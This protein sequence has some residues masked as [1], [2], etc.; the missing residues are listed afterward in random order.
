MG[1]QRVTGEARTFLEDSLTRSPTEGDE[2][3][4]RPIGSR[5]TA[6]MALLFL[7]PW[8]VAKAQQATK[9]WHVGCLHPNPSE[10]GNNPLGVAFEKG[11]AA[12]G[13]VV[14]TTTQIEYLFVRPSADKLRQAAKELS[15]R[16]DVLVVWGTVSAIAAKEAGIETPVVFA[17]VG[18]PVALGLA[19]SLRKPGGNFTGISF[20]AADDTYGK[21]LQMLKEMVPGLRRVA[22]LGAG[23]DRNIGPSLETLH[24]IAPTLGIEL[25]DAK[26]QSAGDLATAFSEFKKKGVQGV[27]VIAGAF[28]Y[29]NSG[30]L[31]ELTLAHRL[32]AVHGFKEA[33]AAGGLISLG[34]DLIVMADQ[35]AM[36]VDKILRG[37]SPG[38]LPVEQPS[39]YEMHINLTSAK[40]L[41]LAVPSSLHV[42]ADNVIQ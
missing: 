3:P 36:Y 19:Q 2:T 13:H 10:A 1:T 7:G 32:P 14:G 37:A 40:Q 27:V 17:S 24:R 15:A 30:L 18:F 23:N 12:R 5:R 39:R 21:R 20:E 4:L 16:A 8:S 33:V 28:M 31:A 35:A 26:V 22:A 6:L 38:D 29:Q 9:V 42:R 34:P 41:G 11:L 25:I